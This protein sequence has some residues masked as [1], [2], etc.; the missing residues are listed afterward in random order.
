MTYNP[1]LMRLMCGSTPEYP[2]GY[3]ESNGYGLF[4]IYKRDWDK[5]GGMNVLDYK[6]KWGGEDWDLVDRVLMAAL[7]IERFK[8]PGLYHYFHPRRG[9]WNEA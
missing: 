8:V 9:M 1:V 7:E 4:A 3:W 5:F 6:H 2:V